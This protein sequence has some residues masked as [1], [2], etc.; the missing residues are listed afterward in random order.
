MSEQIILDKVNQLADG[1]RDTIRNSGCLQSLVVTAGQ[2]LD[3]NSMVADDWRAKFLASNI[4]QQAK[5]DIKSAMFYQSHGEEA[6]EPPENIAALYAMVPGFVRLD[7][8][9]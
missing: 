8:S 4:C 2:G 1:V 3:F 7:P 5:A 9:A 6:P